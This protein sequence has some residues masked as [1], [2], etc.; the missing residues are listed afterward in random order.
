MMDYVI[1]IADTETT[2]LDFINHDIIELSIYRLN[3]HVQKTWC[4]KPLNQESIDA[5]ALRVNGHKLEDLKH[6]TKAG[7]ERYKDPNKVI[8]EVEN[9]LAEDGMPA[10]KRWLVGQNINFDKTMLERLWAKCNS[11]DTFPFGR[12]VLDTMQL[13]FF[14]D[15]CKG[16]MAEAYSLSAIIKKYGIKNEKAHTAEADVKATKE[17]FEKQVEYFKK[18][19]AKNE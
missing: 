17:V 9:W 1:Y 18:M 5:G 8:V 10:E 7:I 16:S 12:R 13:E 11:K 4:L 19:L 2:G 6:Q 3:D 14:L 15:W